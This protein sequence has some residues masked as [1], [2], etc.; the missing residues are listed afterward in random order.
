MSLYVKKHLGNLQMTTFNDNRKHVFKALCGMTPL[1]LID[2]NFLPL[3]EEWLFKLASGWGT[4][5]LMMDRQNL[6]QV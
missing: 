3:G 4:L 1:C 5:T 6:V 2:L